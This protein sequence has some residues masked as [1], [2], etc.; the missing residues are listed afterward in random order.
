MSDFP[1]DWTEW[2]MAVRLNV[3]GMLP[4]DVRVMIEHSGP[5]PICGCEVI[6][7]SSA[8]YDVRP[9]EEYQVTQQCARLSCR[10]DLPTLTY[11]RDVK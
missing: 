10:A 3:E 8:Y 6:D 11:V 9:G 1:Q 7:V 4:T 5:C 2:T